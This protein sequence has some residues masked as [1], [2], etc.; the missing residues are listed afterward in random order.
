M[1]ENDYATNKWK[2]G[3]A[4]NKLKNSE[5]QDVARGMLDSQIKIKKIDIYNK[6]HSVPPPPS[7][8]ILVLTVMWSYVRL[9]FLW[10]KNNNGKRSM[11]MLLHL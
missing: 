6:T 4:K 9:D 3:C 1:K 5:K 7:S 11:T 8:T 2:N 10:K